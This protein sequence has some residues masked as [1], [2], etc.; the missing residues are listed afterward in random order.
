MKI[1]LSPLIILA[2]VWCLSDTSEVMETNSSYFCCGTPR[3]K[4][5][6][7]CETTWSINDKPFAASNGKYVSPCKEIEGGQMM[8]D[9][10]VDVNATIV[11]KDGMGVIQEKRIHYHSQPCPV[12]TLNHAGSQ[13]FDGLLLLAAVICGLFELY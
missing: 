4:F 3:I 9:S 11:C 12:S 1:Y 5:D 7:R 13:G 10:C 6:P 2:A 8:L